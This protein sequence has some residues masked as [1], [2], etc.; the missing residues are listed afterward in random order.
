MRK[1]DAGVSSRKAAPKQSGLRRP[2]LHKLAARSSMSSLPEVESRDK[3][4]N[5]QMPQ[6]SKDATAKQQILSTHPLNQ[7]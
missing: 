5:K 7:Q 1:T 2:N 6:Q 4:T 3:Q